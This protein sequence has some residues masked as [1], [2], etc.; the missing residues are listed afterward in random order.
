V[1]VNDR[2]IFEATGRRKTSTARVSM[3]VPGTGKVTVN[4]REISEYFR[5]ETLVMIVEQPLKITEMFGTC[6]II[7]T[8]KGGGL[9]G[10]AGA[11]RLGLSR[12]LLKKDE[13]LRKPLKLAGFLTR[14]PRMVERKKYGMA[15]ARKRYQFSKR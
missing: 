5:R 15:G 4:T 9:L 6:D 14:D 7:I 10:Q 1:N 3:V 12:A 8:A 11:A 13:S 2:S